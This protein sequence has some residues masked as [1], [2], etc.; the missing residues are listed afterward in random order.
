MVYIYLATVAAARSRAVDGLGGA[1]NELQME[2]SH[3]LTRRRAFSRAAFGPLL[4]V[5]LGVILCAPA[6]H[7]AVSVC[8]AAQIIANEGPTNC[9]APPSM[10]DCQIGADYVASQPACT[11]D[12][13]NRNVFIK[14]TSVIDAGSG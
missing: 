11:F 5:G 10:A 7:A 12:F 4:A 9:P 2:R 3:S 1:S 8:T 13:G 14:G 6:V